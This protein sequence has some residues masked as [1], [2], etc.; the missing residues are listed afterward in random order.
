MQQLIQ[1]NHT[2]S[3]HNLCCV[4]E[5]NRRILKC[6][7][8]CNWT[9][10]KW[11]ILTREEP[12][13]RTHAH[14]KT[15]LQLQY[16]KPCVADANMNRNKTEYGSKR[17]HISCSIELGE[18]VKSRKGKCWEGNSAEKAE[19][20]LGTG[21]H[22]WGLPHTRVSQKTKYER[23]LPESPGR[24]FAQLITGKVLRIWTALKTK[25]KN[26][27]KHLTKIQAC[28]HAHKYIQK[29]FEYFKQWIEK[30]PIAHI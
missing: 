20:P 21:T 26:D 25:K 8:N 4:L 19:C 18:G 3:Q 16:S 7:W 12:S 15:Y 29:T 10:N 22:P 1:H 23:H 6:T 11:T 30:P 27:E 5:I 14:L 24:T 28:M 9:Q 13:W 2:R 17:N